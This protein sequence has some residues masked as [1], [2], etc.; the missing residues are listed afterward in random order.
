MPFHLLYHTQHE[1]QLLSLASL[2]SCTLRPEQVIYLQN[3]YVWCLLVPC[4]HF[5]PSIKYNSTGSDKGGAQS[6]HVSTFLHLLETLCCLC[7]PGTPPVPPGLVGDIRLCWV[8]NHPWGLKTVLEKGHGLVPCL[9]W[10]CKWC[11]W[12]KLP[13]LLPWNPHLEWAQTFYPGSSWVLPLPPTARGCLH[14]ANPGCQE[15]SQPVN[16]H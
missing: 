13:V 5:F 16:L 14:R 12:E 15:I 2:C 10:R 6:C 11:A 1:R 8:L 9:K 4:L 7:C 3:R